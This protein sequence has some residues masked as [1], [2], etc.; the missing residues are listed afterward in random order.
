MQITR[1][2]KYRSLSSTLKAAYL[3]LTS[4]IFSKSIFL[5]FETLDNKN[6]FNDANLCSPLFPLC[7]LLFPLCSSLCALPSLLCP[8][9][10]VLFPLPPS[11]L[12]LH[13]CNYLNCSV[14]HRQ[15]R[16][17][18][19]LKNKMYS[20]LRRLWFSKTADNLYVNT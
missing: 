8:L 5:T 3:P 11:A 12:H 14:L 18:D 9:C 2:S 19:Y 16:C 7:S 10:S 6:R 20:I 17:A 4:S 13:I 1:L 15:C